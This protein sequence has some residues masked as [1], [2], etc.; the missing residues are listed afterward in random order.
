MGAFALPAVPELM[1]MQAGMGILQTVAGMSQ[2]QSQASAQAQAARANAEHQ[3]AVLARQYESESRRRQNLLDRSTARARV[4]FGARGIAP[5]EGSAGALLQ[6]IEDGFRADEADRADSFRLQN[7]GL[8]RGLANSL[9]SLD[10]TR[11]RNL[12]AGGND[13]QRRIFGLLRW[14]K[15]AG[16]TASGNDAY[17][18]GNYYG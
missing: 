12:L 11:E 10:A 16:G 13:I 4:S 18:D 15:S 8:D 14:G 1:A 9:Q 3:R 17:A 2:A 5:G 7:E 6:G